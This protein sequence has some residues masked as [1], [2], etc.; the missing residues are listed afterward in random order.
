M[1]NLRYLVPNGL[2]AAAL[3]CGVIAMAMAMRGE[4]LEA[5]WWVLYATVFDRLDGATARRLDAQSAFGTQFDSFADFVSFGL[6]PAFLY[7][8]ASGVTV[9]WWQILLALVYVLACAGRLSRFNVAEKEKLFNGVPSTMSGGVYILVLHLA[10]KYGLPAEVLTLGLGV[11]LAVF[12]VSMNLPWLRYQ[13]LGTEPSRLGRWTLGTLVL[14]SI[15]LIAVRSLPE[16]V[17]F[18]SGGAMIAGP[19]LSAVGRHGPRSALTHG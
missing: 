4:V 16:V 12:G 1:R 11:L 5:T 2:T 10:L 7:L 17:L 19:V 15:G 9:E 13:K 8:Q 6:A 14:I 18:I 3:S